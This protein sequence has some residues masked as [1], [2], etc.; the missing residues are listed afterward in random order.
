MGG[1]NYVQVLHGDANHKNHELE[2]LFSH[3][4]FLR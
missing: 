1:G 4:I 2:L 3:L